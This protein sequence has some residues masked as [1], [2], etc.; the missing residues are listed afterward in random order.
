MG[1]TLN[2]GQPSG[3]GTHILLATGWSVLSLLS[4][5]AAA[6]C[7]SGLGTTLLTQNWAPNQWFAVFAR[8]RRKQIDDESEKASERKQRPQWSVRRHH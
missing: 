8:I 4:S 2:T 6:A 5:S 3:A 1:R 7:V